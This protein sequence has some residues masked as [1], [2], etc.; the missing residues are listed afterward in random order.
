M[1]RLFGG[2]EI[3]LRDRSRRRARRRLLVKIFA[4]LLFFSLLAYV[5]E[6]FWKPTPDLLQAPAAE[7]SGTDPD[8]IRADAKAP[9]IKEEPLKPKKVSD[10]I[11]PGETLYGA[12]GRYNISTQEIHI[13]ASALRK[14]LSV[15][16]IRAGDVFVLESKNTADFSREM[17]LAGANRFRLK[18]FELVTL[19]KSGVP[20]RYR[21][22][23]LPDDKLGFNKQ[24]SAPI[25]KVKVIDLPVEIHVSTLSGKIESSLYNAIIKAG[26]DGNL[27]NRFTDVFGWQVDFYKE[28]QR[29]DAFKAVVEVRYIQGKPVGYGRILAAEFS[30]LGTAY[31]AF[32]FESR[33][34]RI[35]G[36]FDINGHSLQ[37]I[38]L[39]S[40]L[41]FAR[42]TSRYGQRFHP[43][44]KLQKKHNGV[45]YGAS[46][47]TPFWSIAE[48]I[49]VEAG[50]TRF[51]GNWVRVRHENG[52]MTEYLHAS[53][54][55]AGIRRGLRV[56]QRQ[57]LGY[58]GST[59][60]ATAPH[61][62]FGMKKRGQYVDPSRQKFAVGQ[63]V[64]ASYLT[65]FR[66]SI[67]ALKNELNGL[68][69]G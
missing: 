32:F 36:V 10:R 31:Q 55:A 62:H 2:R 45:D 43:V 6:S 33:N 47:G 35:G 19:D 65:E 57:V 52:Y 15:R 5:T 54:L 30:T 4:W 40:P 60:L 18:A 56:K 21:A 53:R 28:T 23:Y 58:V 34:K 22:E 3:Y 51:N 48:G 67:E 41:E 69:V 1:K 12:L 39:K 26:G 9:V 11:R 38:F 24:P 49:V 8:E 46:T 63:S 13:L 20:V 44:L 61:L 59:G 42:I 25:F 64:P 7:I 29:G 27:V 37:K 66:R 16:T 50:Y 68:N 14:S 17:G